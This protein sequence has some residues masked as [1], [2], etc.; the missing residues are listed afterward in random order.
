MFDYRRTLEHK[1]QLKIY[2]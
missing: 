1:I 2:F